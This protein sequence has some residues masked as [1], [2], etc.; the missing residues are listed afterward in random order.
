MIPASTMFIRGKFAEYYRENQFCTLFPSLIGKREFGFTLFE[1]QMVR[2]KRFNREVELKSFL[3][4]CVPSDAY[5]SC[6]YYEN[7]EAEMDKKGWLGADLIFDIDA[8]HL[9]TPCGKIH[10]TWTCGGCCF[11]GKGVVPEKC[12]VC[13]GEKFNVKTWSCEECLKSARDETVKLLDVLL[14]DFGFSEKEVHVFF[15]GHRGY[16]VHVE[17][18]S[19]KMLDTIA[20]KDVVDYVCA[21]GLDMGFSNPTKGRSGKPSFPSA[22]RLDDPGW[23]G[24]IA[25][26]MYDLV[27][28]G[29]K[30]DYV[31]LGLKRNVVDAI[32]T[33][34]DTILKS[35]NSVGPYHAARGVGFETWGKI[36]DFCID[37][38]SAKV[39]T[40]VTT[41]IHRL[42]RLA[43]AL[44]GKTGLKKM[45][46]P[47]ANIE[48]F[49]PFKQAV[50]FKRGTVR[51]LVSDA[52]KFTLGDETFGPYRNQKVELPTAAAILL[53]CRRRAE[54]A[55]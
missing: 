38:M 28:K 36:V 27:L 5:F 30:E 51:V 41:D 43:G 14:Q 26:C 54:I 24:R 8:D 50:A 23:R 9:V 49:D 55:E 2:H 4:A 13:G 31:K 44:H 21:L 48:D 46:F 35:W 52:P 45:E 33:N 39:D 40:V 29:Q 11:E 47:I 20:R 34:R 1:G 12:P 22:S 25:Q 17:A 6:A 16:H 18:E 3:Q 15:S 10:D 42:I 7:P 37:S 32:T 19:V 53:I